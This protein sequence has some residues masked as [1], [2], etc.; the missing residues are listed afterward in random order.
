MLAAYGISLLA[1]R[2]ATSE[3]E[4]V[5]IA[6]ETGYPVAVKLVSRTITH[7]SI[8]YDRA[9]IL[10]AE[11]VAQQTGQ[12]EIMAVGRLVKIRGTSD[13][14]FAVVVS[15]QFQGRGLGSEFL[16][17][18]I[19]IG[20]DECLDCVVAEVLPEKRDMQRIFEKFGF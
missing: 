10:V 13:G 15:D 6:R 3:A 2:L 18:L 17:R 19:Q 7:K 12:R 9:M 8:D 11:R 5:A 4:A 14:E 20:R 16:R 1:A